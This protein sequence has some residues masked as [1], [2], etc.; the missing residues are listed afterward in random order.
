MSS[1][2]NFSQ[3]FVAHRMEMPAYPE[4]LMPSAPLNDHVPGF[5]VVGWMTR[6]PLQH[7][8]DD[9]LHRGTMKIRY[10]QVA[11][12][13]LK[14][15]TPAPGMFPTDHIPTRLEAVKLKYAKELNNV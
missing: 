13:F 14:G 10:R 7:F 12:A 5:A 15:V 1:S 2:K 9:W 11:K 6:F 3:A 8:G 4:H